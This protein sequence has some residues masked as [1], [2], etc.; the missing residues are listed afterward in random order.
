MSVE[1]QDRN[2]VKQTD[3]YARTL[4]SYFI[5]QVPAH[6]SYIVTA[7]FGV[8]GTIVAA[9]IVNTSFTAWSFWL[10]LEFLSSLNFWFAIVLILV[11]IGFLFYTYGRLLLYNDLIA[12]LHDYLGLN[13]Q[14]GRQYYLRWFGQIGELMGDW[15]FSGIIRA[16]LLYRIEK[17]KNNEK[18]FP[19]IH[20][21]IHRRLLRLILWRQRKDEKT[22]EL[23]NGLRKIHVSLYDQ[24]KHFYVK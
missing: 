2:R 14:W 5:N 20:G 11:S 6:A 15:N 19:H 8:F 24:F 4:L 10:R 16:E 21:W 3:E 18:R 1:E 12:V 9:F 7:L 22:I 13:A 23:V 17:P